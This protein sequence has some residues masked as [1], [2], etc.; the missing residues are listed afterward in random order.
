VEL[1][2]QDA[3]GAYRVDT[4]EQI[5]LAYDVAGLGSRFLAALVDAT[6]QV[7]LF[8]LIWFVGAVGAGALIGLF[9]DDSESAVSA[10]VVAGAVLGTFATL[11]GYHVFFEMVWHGQTPGKRWLGLR[12]IKEGGYPLGFVDSVIRNVVRLV[13]FLPFSYLIGAVVMFVDRRSRRLGDLAAGT[14]VVKE[15]RELRLEGVTAGLFDRSEGAAPAAPELTRLTPAD[16]SLLR[17]YTRR[18]ETLA[19]AARQSLAARL[20]PAIAA[21]IGR[22]VGPEGADG[23]LIGLAAELGWREPGAGTAAAEL[24]ASRGQPDGPRQ[25]RG[26]PARLLT[27]LGVILLGAVVVAAVLGF[28]FWPTGDDGLGRDPTPTV[29][30]VDG[31]PRPGPT[32]GIG[33]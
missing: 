31:A 10:A 15:R 4:P 25:R 1:R 18:R 6:I 7:L 33:R 29:R 16:R 13:D 14:L 30:A 3:V 12:V 28:L 23:F 22:A 8:G 26:V 17:E 27:P 2:E 24:A 9:G 11:W 21:K 32:A 20:A 19:D 5:D